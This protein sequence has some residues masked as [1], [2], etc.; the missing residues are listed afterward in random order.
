MNYELIPLPEFERQVKRLQK[1]FRNI[2]TD[3]L[4]LQKVL[5]SNPKAGEPI[6]GLRGKIYKLRHASSDLERGKSGGFRIIY[7]FIHSDQNIYLLTIYPKSEKENIQV[8]EIVKL[9]KQYG[10]W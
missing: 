8:A 2:R 4:D 1:K 5:L 7:Y 10:L 3:L 6:R 9:L